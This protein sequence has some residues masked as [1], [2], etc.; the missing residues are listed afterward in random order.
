[1]G[2]VRHVVAWPDPGRDPQYAGR[3]PGA[4]RG[5]DDEVGLPTAERGRCGE[6]LGSE[7]ELGAAARGRLQ[8]SPGDYLVGP[9]GDSLGE[10]RVVEPWTWDV[11]CV[12]GHGRSEAGEGEAEAVRWRPDEGDARLQDAK[13]RRLLLDAEALENRDHGRHERFPNQQFWASAVVEERDL[14]TLA[15][16]E[17]RER[18]SAGAGADDGHPQNGWL[19]RRLR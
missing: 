13:H 8:P 16:E 19:I 5:V 11:V 14:G 6:G 1:M 2:E 4:T 9:G 10:Q 3:E 15:S 12:G 7:R 17:G 18:G